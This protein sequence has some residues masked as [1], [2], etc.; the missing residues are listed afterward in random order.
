MADKR[1]LPYSA[2]MSFDAN[3]ES[4]DKLVEPKKT[5][6]KV[7]IAMIIGVILFFAIGA[8]TLLLIARR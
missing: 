6:T 4:P 8:V 2:G 7:N 5:T 1:A 3:H